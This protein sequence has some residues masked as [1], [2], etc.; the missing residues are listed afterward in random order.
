[1]AA[2]FGEL[3]LEVAAP[4]TGLRVVAG[5]LG[6]KYGWVTTW[7]YGWGLTLTLSALAL[8]SSGYLLGA[9]ELTARARRRSCWW[10]C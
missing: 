4:G 5:L 9:L 2:V 1:M 8:A 10:H 7:A 6:A 3:G